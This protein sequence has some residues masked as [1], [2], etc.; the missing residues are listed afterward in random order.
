MSKVN[1]V[2]VT[3]GE[4]SHVRH[5]SLEAFLEIDT[6]DKIHPVSTTHH[7]Q[8]QNKIVSKTTLDQHGLCIWLQSRN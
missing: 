8:P 6:V 3:Y 2:M 4:R 1:V 7:L 5:K